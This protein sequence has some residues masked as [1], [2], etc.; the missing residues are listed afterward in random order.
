MKDLK[1]F[2]DM[3]EDRGARDGE[4]AGPEHEAY[5]LGFRHSII[6]ITNEIKCK[7]CLNSTI[8]KCKYCI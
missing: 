7:E 5:L 2:K 1:G 4:G 6:K 3:R 8:F